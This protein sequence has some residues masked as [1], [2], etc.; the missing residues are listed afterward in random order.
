MAL[1]SASSSSIALASIS[2]TICRGAFV[3]TDP[4]ALS[5]IAIEHPPTLISMMSAILAG[6]I[7]SRT[8][9]GT[10]VDK[11]KKFYDINNFNIAYKRIC[12]L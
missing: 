10:I 5:M 7:Q 11:S 1:T 2:N 6:G 8:K 3:D 12:G 4:T 9:L